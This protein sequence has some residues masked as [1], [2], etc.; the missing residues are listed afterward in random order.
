MLIVVVDRVARGY[1]LF[2]KG[3]IRTGIQISIETREVAATDFKPQ[4]VSFAK[5]IA[6]GPQVELELVDLPRVH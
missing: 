5:H 3:G 1:E 2:S 6:G 4:Y